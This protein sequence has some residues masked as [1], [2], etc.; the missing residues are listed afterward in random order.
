LI[1]HRDFSGHKHLNS[2]GIL[3]RDISIESVILSSGNNAKSGEESLIAH[4]DYV[5]APDAYT[6]DKARNIRFTEYPEIHNYHEDRHSQ[7]VYRGP[8]FTSFAWGDD[9]G[10][11]NIER[12]P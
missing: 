12:Y 9:D 11:A 8:Y 6:N 7:G 3:H 5:G 2:L 1:S 10:E 4:L